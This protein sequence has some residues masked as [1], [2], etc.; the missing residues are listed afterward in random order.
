MR[1]FAQW[2]ALVLALLFAGGMLFHS[3]KEW[4]AA[5]SLAKAAETII[6]LGRRW[7]ETLGE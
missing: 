3:R 2:L 4:I 6:H 1:R 7:S 5:S